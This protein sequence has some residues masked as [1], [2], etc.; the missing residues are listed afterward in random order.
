M[1][2]ALKVLQ[3]SRSETVDDMAASFGTTLVLAEKNPLSI[4]VAHYTWSFCNLV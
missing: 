4:L 3:P 2:D 1:R